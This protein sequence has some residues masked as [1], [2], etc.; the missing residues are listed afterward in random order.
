MPK[1]DKFPHNF[2]SKSLKELASDI[3]QPNEFIREYVE[4][5]NEAVPLLRA[6]NVRDGE[7]NISDLVYVAKTKLKGFEASY[8]HAGDILITRTG[9]KAGETCIVPALTRDLII[10]SHSIRVIPRTDLIEPKYLELFLLSR[11]GKAQVNRLFTGAAQK[12]LQLE[13][14]AGIQ[15]AVPSTARQR[16]LV[17]VMDAAQAA[18]QQKLAAADA[19]LAG[20]DNYLLSQLGLTPP[21]ADHRQV[22]AVRLKHLA[23]ERLDADYYRPRFVQLLAAIRK[24]ACKP[25][26]DLIELSHEQWNPEK[27]TLKTFRY[28]EISGVNRKTGEVT[29][30]ETPVAEA[31]S[32]AR[33]LTRRN[34]LIVSLTRPH[35]GSIAAID[36]EHD[37]CICSTGFAVLRGLKDDS[38]GHEYLLGILRSSLCLEQM[39]Q[40]SSGG[41]Y[42]AITE[43]EL[44]KIEIPVPAPEIQ[45]RIVVEQLR[46][47]TEARRLRLAAAAE[48]SAAKAHFEQKLL[49]GKTNP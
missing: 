9:A 14:V 5:S 22:F 8:I 44:L 43:N 36:A 19:L 6:G 7:L 2:P 45:K 13:T 39:L 26:G 46:R 16:E 17:S 32:R 15:I 1:G 47:R 30:E 48:W 10:S 3:I 27:E 34:D 41:N 4:D 18:R 37:G 23:P 20:L 28:I 25:L 38:V 24:A 31:P 40:R 49:G 35:H 12:Q 33:M 42:P 21:P 11:W 29:A